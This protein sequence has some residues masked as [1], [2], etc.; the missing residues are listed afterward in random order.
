MAEPTAA[1]FAKLQAQVADLNNWKAKNVG[2]INSALQNAYKNVK[3]NESHISKLKSQMSD[4]NSWKDRNAKTINQ[5]LEHAYKN[6]KSN[7]GQ[8]AKIEKTIAILQKELAAL[9]KKK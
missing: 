4:M 7:E 3:E 6:V 8:I 9:R 2:T 1:D 5:A